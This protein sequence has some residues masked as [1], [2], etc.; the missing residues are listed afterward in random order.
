MN[1][2]N[3]ITLLEG[4]VPK[5]ILR[6]ALPLAWGMFAMTSFS[7]VD[8][9][10]I[11]QLGTKYL[12]A[13]GFSIPVVMLYMGV[14]FGLNVGTSTALSRVYGE[15]DMVRFRRMATD[16]LVLTALV[17]TIAAVV[18]FL[19]ITPIF[20][21]MGA[22]EQTLPLIWRYMAI[23]YCSLP[24]LGVMMVG[25]A[26]IRATGDTR[27]PSAVMT[28]LA[29]LNIIFDPLYI[30]GWGPFPK[31]DL[32]GAAATQVTS[33]YITC[34]ISLFVLI[35]RKDMLA[36]PIWHK[37]I[38][39]SWKSILHVAIP[40]VIS[41]QIGPISAGIITWLAAGFGR[42]AVAALGVATRI[43]SMA[44]LIFYSTGAGVSIFIG[45]N[46]GAGNYGRIQEATRAGVKYAFIWGLFVA[47][48]LWAFA[49]DIPQVFDSHPDVI[50]YT[51]QYLH[52]VPLSYA[53]LGVMVICNARQNSV[54]RPFRATF[55][56]LLKAVIIYLPLAWYAQKIFGFLGILVALT[57]TNFAV[58]LIAHLWTRKPVA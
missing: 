43:E 8:T 17:V 14:I 26:C 21:L 10:F 19:L 34:M 56:I 35:F 53:A 7:I 58:G 33:C 3:R 12:A 46:F 6:L 48:I 44:T 24:F 5:H 20:R 39:A 11:S 32:A 29:L 23:W 25:N 30:F 55:M 2:A 49:Y 15:G 31:M 22:G 51:A 50:A 42:E 16:A 40:S 1:A 54:G 41:N 27:F 28:G 37:D 52:W 9:W 13:L 4:D 57:I 18:G 47:V 36:G 38:V 45:Q